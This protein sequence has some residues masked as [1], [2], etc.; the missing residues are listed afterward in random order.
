[1]VSPTPE[2]NGKNP[3]WCQSDAIKAGREVNALLSYIRNAGKTGP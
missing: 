2:A 3:E 1:M